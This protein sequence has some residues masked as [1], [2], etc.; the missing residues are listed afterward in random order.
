[1]E[2]SVSAGKCDKIVS[3]KSRVGPTGEQ[4]HAFRSHQCGQ[5]LLVLDCY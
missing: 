4:A 5:T 2:G 1:M 3:V